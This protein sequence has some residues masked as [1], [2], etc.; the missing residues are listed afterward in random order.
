MRIAIVNLQKPQEIA[1]H[2]YL[3]A[4]KLSEMTKIIELQAR[5][6]ESFTELIGTRA[7]L[8][9]KSEIHYMH[10]VE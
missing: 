9:R 8:V 1:E 3:F 6:I 7:D 4:T 10:T 2:K 5:Y